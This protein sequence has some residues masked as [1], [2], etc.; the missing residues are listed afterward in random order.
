MSRNINSQDRSEQTSGNRRRSFFLKLAALGGVLLPL[1]AVPADTKNDG[2]DRI[3]ALQREIASLKHNVGR[4]EDLNEIRK[5]QH[6]YGYYLDK[7]L[8]EEV[9]QLFADDSQVRFMGGIWKGKAG[10]RRLYVGVF[11]SFFTGGKNAPVP[12][13]LLDHP[14]LQDVID[15]SPDRSSATPQAMVGRRY[16]RERVCTRRWRLEDQTPELQ[17]GLACRFRQRLGPYETRIHPR[18]FGDLSGQSQRAG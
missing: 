6:T 14:Q 4:L 12:G 15:V 5:L 1:K 11:G 2:Q 18:L 10:V 13:F 17:S 3:D 16:L 7:C 9:A 8:Y